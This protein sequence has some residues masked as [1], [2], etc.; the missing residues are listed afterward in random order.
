LGEKGARI[1]C[2]KDL[3]FKSRQRLS[4]ALGEVEMQLVACLGRLLEWL[5]SAGCYRVLAQGRVQWL[6]VGD[7][8]DLWKYRGVYYEITPDLKGASFDEGEEPGK[9]LALFY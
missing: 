5:A 3:A 7:R 1:S 6:N 2:N 9:C 8:C 4:G